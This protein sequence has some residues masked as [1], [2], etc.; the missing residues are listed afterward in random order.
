M[1]KYLIGGAAGVAAG[2]PLLGAA[3]AAATQKTPAGGGNQNAAG[4]STPWG[5]GGFTDDP[6]GWLTG[7]VAFNDM[8]GMMSPVQNQFQAGSYQ[9]D[10]NAFRIENP[11]VRAAQISA[12]PQGQVRG[13]QSALAALMN[14]RAMG[15]GP[16][17][18]ELQLRSTTDSNIAAARSGAAGSSNPA[19]AGRSAIDAGA[20]MN[21]Q[22][23]NQASVLRAQEQAQAQGALGQML[24]GQRGQ[25]LGLAGQQA[26][27]QQQ[28]A[29]QN[30]QAHIEQQR[31]LADQQRLQAEQYMRA[32]EMN[33]Q[34]SA[35]NAERQ[36]Q[37]KGGLFSAAGTALGSML[38]DKRAKASIRGAD[39]EAEEFMDGLGAY[40]YKYKSEEHG[41]GEH[42]GVMAQDVARSKAGKRIVNERADGL[43]EFDG[44]KTLGA[45]LAASANL[46]KRV[47]AV[48][49]VG[50]LGA[51]LANGKR[52]AAR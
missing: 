38:S 47:R 43:L 14:Q 34:T 37:S 45:L 41:K 48:E 28:A 20:A 42:L 4:F 5:K 44:K 8:T 22:A 26:G 12:G 27:F 15:R 21:Q 31:A 29:I 25:D 2:D 50:G 11:D 36:Q 32:Q 17:A 52:Q 23:A 7:E 18:A 13:Q 24:A 6:R 40:L 33:R 19:L 9:S 1:S 3:A 51:I 35:E 46:N 49:R 10:P 39:A 16:S 30:Q